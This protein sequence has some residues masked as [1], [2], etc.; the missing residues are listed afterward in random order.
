M[1]FL[2][3]TDYRAAR[4]SVIENQDT[5]KTRYAA[6]QALSVGPAGEMRM[7]Y[8]GIREERHDG[9]SGVEGACYPRERALDGMAE[10]PLKIAGEL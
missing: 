5:C 2:L 10:A 7:R 6:R 4:A 8:G 3:G 9:A 1:A